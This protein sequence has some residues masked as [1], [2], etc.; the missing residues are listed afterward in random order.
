MDAARQNALYSLLDDPSPTVQQALREE[1]ARYGEDAWALIKRALHSENESLRRAAEKLCDEVR[2]LDPAAEF[3][4]FIRSYQ[5]ELETGCLLLER[6]VNPALDG[7]AYSAQ[8]DELANRVRELTVVPCAAIERCRIISR[9]LFHEYGFRGDAE[10][11][12]NPENSC[13]S[14]VLERRKGLPITLGIIYLLVAERT[15]FELEAVCPPQRFMVGCF[16]QREPIFIDAFER[17]RMRVAS[18]VLAFLRDHGV[19]P[20]TEMLMPTPIGEVLCRC[21]RNL[22]RQF[23]ARGETDKARVYA[24]FCE[25]FDHA[26][27][28]HARSE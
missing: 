12:D 28:R 26:Y 22:C 13:L 21:C 24:D 3:T 4:R 18:E 10:D 23:N 9:V 16:R 14:R 11:F 15:G 17:G 25:E 7:G 27:Q 6:T 20:S 2:I 1:I 8:L 5:Y 19:S